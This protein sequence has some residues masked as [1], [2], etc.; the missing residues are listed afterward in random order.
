M[1]RKSER[2]FRNLKVIKISSDYIRD[3]FNAQEFFLKNG[4]YV[5]KSGNFYAKLY[6]DVDKFQNLFSDCPGF[7]QLRKIRNKRFYENIYNFKAN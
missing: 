2:D 1:Q 5:I 4:F 6:G 7:I 3:L